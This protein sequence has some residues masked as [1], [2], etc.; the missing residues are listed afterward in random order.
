MAAGV[1]SVK[2]AS[3]H[4]RVDLVQALEALSN[5]GIER[6]FVEGGGLVATAFLK[7]GCVDR[8]EWFRA[9][10]ILGGDGRQAIGFLN[11][12][13]LETMPRFTRLNVQA[14]G[15]DLWESYELIGD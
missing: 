7:M 10:A 8:L 9:P 5:L 11:I 12:E 1:K 3:K 14:V 2:V 13:D 6:L 4:Q 15:D